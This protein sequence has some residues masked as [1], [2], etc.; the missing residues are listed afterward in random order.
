MDNVTLTLFA[1]VLN[2]YFS[3]R[4]V[5][6]KRKKLLFPEMRVTRKIS[7]WAVANLFFLIDL[8]KMLSFRLYF[9]LMFCILVFLSVSLLVF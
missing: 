4:D 7:I 5:S 6:P 8:L 9:L 1:D 3:K 2:E